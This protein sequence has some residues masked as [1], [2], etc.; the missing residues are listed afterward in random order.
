[1]PEDNFPPDEPMQT[2]PAS[3][4]VR[5]E[6]DSSTPPSIAVVET[7][8]AAT[9]TAPTDLPPIAHQIDPDALDQLCS[10]P[11]GVHV[12]FRYADVPVSIDSTGVVVAH[13]SDVS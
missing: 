9:G 7:V 5:V 11:E 10:G 6:W 2:D 12:W 4:K 8:A 3:G 1:M 13:V